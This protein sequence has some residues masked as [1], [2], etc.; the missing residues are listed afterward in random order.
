MCLSSENLQ[1][2]LLHRGG[3]GRPGERGGRAD[4]AETAGSRQPPP[5]FSKPKMGLVA[6]GDSG[7]EEFVDAEQFEITN[8]V[9]V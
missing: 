6:G 2:F 3:A 8:I 5:S 9:K 1:E 7:D 4:G